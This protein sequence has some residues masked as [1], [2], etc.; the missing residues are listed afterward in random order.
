MRKRAAERR[1]LALAP[2][3]LLLAVLALAGGSAAP[4][5]RAG[6]S[7]GRAA[8]AAATATPTPAW[9]DDGAT[10]Q[11]VASTGCGAAPAVAS[12]T[13]AEQSVAVNPATDEGFAT[14]SYWVH[15]P[16]GYDASRPTALVLVFHG[17]GG[18]GIG[19]EAA[20]GL[21]ALADQQGFLVA[22]PQGLPYREAGPGYAS[23]A[24][25]GPLDTFASGVDDL[26]FVST[27]LDALQRTYCVDPRR[28]YATG[29][30][31]GGAMTAFLTC[32][33]T[34]RIAAFA[35][36][37]GDAYQFKGGCFPRHPT[38]I[39]E[40]HGAADPHELYVG[41]PAREDPDWRRTGVL[42][43][44]TGW[45]RR[46]GCA[47]GPS[48]FLRVPPALGEEWTGCRPGLAVA[49]YLIAGLGH[50]WPPPIGGRSA[51]EILWDFFQAHPLVNA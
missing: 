41:I 7:A 51:A 9:P 43:W 11:P 16:R 49:H 18:T 48:G 20:T 33:L 47:R 5:R 10:D 34:G 39:L 15:V 2:A 36:L 3:A 42:E 6:A 37:S 17:G 4:T 26:L 40:F 8:P 32:G 21:S 30:S 35:P 24:A 22:Y 46:D 50:S 27:L 29:F 1:A 19:M 13:T 45:A 31:A 28:I 23:W 14:R 38:S 44:L 12:G 25:T